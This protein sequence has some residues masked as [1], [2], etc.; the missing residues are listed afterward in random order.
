V[1]ELQV[2]V[3]PGE[4]GLDEERLQ[5][6]G[7][8]LDGLVTAGRIPGWLVVVA[9][10]GKIAYLHTRGYRHIEEQLPVEIDTIFR[11]YSMTK[12][13][14]SVAAMILLEEGAFELTTPVSE[15]I[16]SFRDMRIYV[17]G[18]DLKPVTVPAT[19]PVRIWH[20]LT[21]TS[22]LTYGFH[23]VHPV[24]ALLRQAGYEWSF[25]DDV[26][27]EAAV[28]TVAA[29]PLLFEPGTEWNYSLSTDV[30]GRVVEIASGTALDRFFADRIFTPLGMTDTSFGLAGPDSPDAA[31]LA[32]LYAGTP[33]GKL[34]PYDVLGNRFLYPATLPSGGGGLLSTAPD[35]H[36]FATM[37]RGGGALD[38]VRI[39]GP[40]TV[41]A[42]TRNWLPGNADLDAFGRPLFAETPYRGVGFGLGFAVVIDPSRAGMLASVGDYSWGGAA[43]TSFWVDP[44]EDLTCLF[45]TQTFPSSAL[46]VRGVLRQ[47]VNQAIVA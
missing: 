19:E 14:T 36:R 32:R 22:G 16:P 40:R 5:R 4:V 10:G 1:G 8:Y 41:A 28:D 24:D 13:V 21:H 44:A 18:S 46:P 34:V 3:E 38:G 25:P 27:L 37:L 2:E 47:L 23:R 12:P 45:M 20:L 15:L 7:T 43:S 39:L 26:D 11:I 6:L 35:Y 33:T 29:Q 9:R 30:L 17:G 42:M 31:R